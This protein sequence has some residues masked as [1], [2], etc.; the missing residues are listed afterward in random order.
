MTGLE[1]VKMFVCL[2]RHMRVPLLDDECLSRLFNLQHG[3]NGLR[4]LK[5]DIDVCPSPQT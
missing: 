4:D 2:N 3:P 5:I 1:S